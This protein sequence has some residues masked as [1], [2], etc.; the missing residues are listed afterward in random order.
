MLNNRIRS[1][2]VDGDVDILS[3]KTVFKGFFQVDAYQLRHRLFNGGWS[4]VVTREICDTGQVSGVLLYDPERKK[5]ILIEQF[6]VALLEDEVSSWSM[7]VV[8]GLQEA[9]ETKESLAV[10]EAKEEANA[11]VLQLIPICEYWE[12][13]GA[14]NK[15]VSLFCGIVDATN[16]GG[17]SG[18]QHE[19]E[20]IR[21]HVVDTH[22][23]F[24]MVRQGT[25]NNGL[26]IIALQWLELNLYRFE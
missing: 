1:G 11:D 14:S 17:I 12:S 25:I 10:R 23:A 8:A 9:T 21:V 19:N 18:L 5:V 20:D 24:E 4:R 2:T 16:L 13:P 22:E 6:R 15:R 3:K 26:A 7:E